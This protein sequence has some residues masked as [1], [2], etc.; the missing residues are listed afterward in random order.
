MSSDPPS[1]DTAAVTEDAIFH[2]RIRLRQHR[3]GYRFTEDAV[4][5]AAF[6]AFGPRAER[7]AD[8]GAGCGVVGLMLLH[9]GAA[10]RVLAVELQPSLARLCADNATLNQAAERLRTLRADLRA[11]P[12]A[13]G[14][15]DLIASNPPYLPLGRGKSPADGER[16]LARHEVACS[17]AA[18]A[19]E[20][21][22][23]LAP[24]GRLA[25]VYPA[26]RLGEVL[27]AIDEAE[28]A[29][30]RLRMVR[31]RPGA[32]PV[33][34]LLEAVGAHLKR[35]FFQHPF[36]VTRDAQGRPTPEMED[37]LAG[38]APSWGGAF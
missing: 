31:P 9:H 29:P 25:L 16:A 21:A 24:E 19:A 23:C 30:S 15:L 27:A 37:L 18:L 34:F 38:R 10:R 5:L 12:F 20:A 11:S 33:L 1:P 28:L 8:L 14:S 7:A 4:L 13:A 2:G 6:A 36:L 32:E 17:P 26:W 3:R 35:P 22:R